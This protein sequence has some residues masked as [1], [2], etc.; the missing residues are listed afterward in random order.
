[1][2]HV[3][4]DTL[5]S[6]RQCTTFPGKIVQVLT[7]GPGPSP[8]LPVSESLLDS[9]LELHLNSGFPCRGASR[10][11]DP[12]L[13]V[14]LSAKW[15]PESTFADRES[16]L[17]NIARDCLIVFSSL[18]YTLTENQSGENMQQKSKHDGQYP[19][20]M[21][22][23]K[24]LRKLRGARIPKF[25]RW[26]A[27]LPMRKICGWVHLG[28]FKYFISAFG[29]LKSFIIPLSSKTTSTKH[30]PSPSPLQPS[31]QVIWS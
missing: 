27:P 25:A 31:P 20:K 19:N 8:T 24:K 4:Q 30:A 9:T 26:R 2:F 13:N 6:Y 14:L 3:T 29:H 17:E 1:M 22:P 21:S 18:T 12:C 15:Q 5:N 16:S 23:C 28:L 7:P 10:Q 11:T